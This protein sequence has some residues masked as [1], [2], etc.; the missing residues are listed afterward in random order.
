VQLPTGQ[1]TTR[2]CPHLLLRAVLRRGCRRAPAVQ[3][4]IDIS[5][6]PGPQQQIRNSG[7]LHPNAW[8]DGQTD[9]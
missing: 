2:Q 9:A 3:Q 6:P 8:T 7:V 1:L 4:P 5:C